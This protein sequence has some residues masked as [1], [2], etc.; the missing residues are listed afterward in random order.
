MTR[1]ELAKICAGYLESFSTGDAD[2]VAAFVADDFV[3]DH[4]AALGSSC[5]GKDEY[6]RRLPNFM[7]SMPGIRY[8]IEQQFVDVDTSTVGNAYIL[9]ARVNDR[10]CAVR[11]LLRIQI[12]PNSGLI[13]NRTDYWDSKVFLTQAGL[14]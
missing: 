5:T 7:A 13:L 2:L 11:G 9:H 6:R 3:N 14:E 4:T 10:D 1:D 8:E 12:D